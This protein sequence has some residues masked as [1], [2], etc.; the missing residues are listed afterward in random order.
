[1]HVADAAEDRRRAFT[2]LVKT[3][4]QVRRAAR[5]RV[6]NDRGREQIHAVAVGRPWWSRV[7]Q[8][9][10]QGPSAS[11]S[12]TVRGEGRTQVSSRVLVGDQERLVEG[13][14]QAA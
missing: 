10:S 5:L 2:L 8:R 12:I 13:R 14:G 7:E 1:V 11:T 9:G 3:Y 4:D 6:L